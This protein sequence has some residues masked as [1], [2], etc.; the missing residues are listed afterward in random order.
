M[1]SENH[2]AAVEVVDAGVSKKKR[3]RISVSAKNLRNGVVDGAFWNT[4]ND[5][6]SAYGQM[7]KTMVAQRER[8]GTLNRVAQKYS[9][10]LTSKAVAVTASSNP[11]LPPLDVVVI[12]AADDSEVK[13]AAPSCKAS[14]TVTIKGA[15]SYGRMLL[16]KVAKDTTP[17]KEAESVAKRWDAYVAKQREGND[18]SDEDLAKLES[19]MTAKIAEALETK[20]AA[21]ELV[22]AAELLGAAEKEMSISEAVPASK[23]SSVAKTSAAPVPSAPTQQTPQ[24]RRL[25]AAHKKSIL[26]L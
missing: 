6:A 4:M 8:F 13:K 22:S 26:G 7:E 9:S 12:S 21:N 19:E 11:H 5:F 3:Q 16:G 10:A 18:L 2:S 25:V 23:V 20:R 15:I 24:M 17:L 14:K 1:E